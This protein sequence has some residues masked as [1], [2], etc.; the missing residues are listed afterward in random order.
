MGVLDSPLYQ[1]R[2]LRDGVTKIWKIELSSE[3]D[4]S[5]WAFLDCCTAGR[6]LVVHF[7]FRYD[8][9]DDF[10]S[11]FLVYG[12]EVLDS[13]VTEIDAHHS[14]IIPNSEASPRHQCRSFSLHLEQYHFSKP[15][16]RR[17]RNHPNHVRF[18]F[19]NHVLLLRPSPFL[20]PPPPSSSTALHSLRAS[21]G[22][23]H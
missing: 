18:R 12:I 4:G 8:R 23:A 15:I 14:Y 19:Q 16:L 1:F 17:R 10:R 9:V 2:R 5:T 6:T 22:T 20:L 13:N 11:S 21:G 3:G 7:M